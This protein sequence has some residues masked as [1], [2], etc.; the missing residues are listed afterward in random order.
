M[1][2]LLNFLRRE[3]LQKVKNKKSSLVNNY[4]FLVG[5]QRFG[6]VSLKFMGELR[7]DWQTFSVES[8]IV[9]LVAFEGQIS[10]LD[11]LIAL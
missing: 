6:A 1:T 9:D 4:I 7:Q 11:L 5:F 8:Q 3:P 2:F 10:Q